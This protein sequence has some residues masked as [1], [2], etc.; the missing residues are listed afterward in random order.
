MKI[1]TSVSFFHMLEG[2]S[3]EQCLC[4]PRSNVLFLLV[5]DLL[6]SIVA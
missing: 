5:P 4:E 2:I 1:R 3:R 6:N